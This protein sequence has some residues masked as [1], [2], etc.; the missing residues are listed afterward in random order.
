MGKNVITH[1]IVQV[2]PKNSN[3]E[4]KP[5]NKSLVKCSECGGYCTKVAQLVWSVPIN[6]YVYN[7]YELR[8]SCCNS[9]YFEN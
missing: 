5:D 7:F 4:Y 6:D 2:V 1:E 9:L 8:S 3:T